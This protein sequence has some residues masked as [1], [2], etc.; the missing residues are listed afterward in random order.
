MLKIIPWLVCVAVLLACADSLKIYLNGGD[1]NGLRRPFSAELDAFSTLDALADASEIYFFNRTLLGRRFL[2]T[3]TA[4]IAET[5]L[6][7]QMTK[8]AYLLRSSELWM[9]PG[10]RISWCDIGDSHFREP[11]Q[12]I[13]C[14]NSSG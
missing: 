10:V 8:R 6:D 3:E 11:A 12:P 2:R 13:M 4:D 1:K 9:W 7:L 14:E 5:L